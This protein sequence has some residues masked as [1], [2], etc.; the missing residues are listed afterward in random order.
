MTKA[1][2]RSLVV[3]PDDS[4]KPLFDAIASAKETI[5]VKM[6]ELSDPSAVEALIAAQ[7]RGVTVRVM[8]DPTRA[9]RHRERTAA[10]RR[11]RRAGVHV[12]ASSPEFSATHEKSLIVDEETAFVQSCNWEPEYFTHTRDYAVRTTNCD[13]VAEIIKCF[14]ADWRRRHFQPAEPSSLIWCPWEGRERFAHFIDRARQSLVVENDRFEDPIIIEHVVRARVRGVKVHVLTRPVHS[15]S[16]QNLAA[17]VSALQTMHDVGVKIHKL[18]HLK[19]HG[20]VM[21]ADHSKAIIGSINISVGSFDK[22]RELAIEVT[23]DAI[24]DRLRTVY[25]RDWKRSK[26]LD[27]SDKGL[28]ADLERHDLAE[29]VTAL[30]IPG[31]GP[32]GT[33][34]G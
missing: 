24:V 5:R 26:A 12:L 18:E 9:R 21:L 20:K 32:G 13:E 15:L 4:P 1:P 29:G 27:L 16:E 6:F 33:P 14:E 30:G 28:A 34:S 7:Q 10:R 2:L 22:R 8:V 17:G 3:L 23:D 11:L 19:L 25:D 31:R